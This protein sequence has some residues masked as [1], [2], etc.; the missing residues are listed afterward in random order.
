[1][2]PTAKE[3]SKTALIDLNT[4]SY[5][6]RAD[7]AGLLVSKAN[8][9]ADAAIIPQAKLKKGRAYI[10]GATSGSLVDVAA[11]HAAIAYYDMALLLMRPFDG[12]Y[13]TVANWKCNALTKLGQFETAAAWYA[14]IVRVDQEANGGVS[15]NAPTA[16]LAHRQ[17]ARFANKENEPLSYR[18]SDTDDFVA[19]P[20]TL[21]AQQCVL[22]LAKGKF[23]DGS[24]HFDV[25]DRN[26]FSAAYLK[27]QWKALVGEAEYSD[28]SITLESYLFEWDGKSTDD[29]GW[30]YFAVSSRDLHEGVECIVKRTGPLGTAIHRIAFGRP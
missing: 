2:S 24:M 11:L 23:A 6:H 3:A 1:M 20:F 17:L 29:I 18:D 4:L 25:G 9:L 21:Y 28:L 19:P 5:R 26:H 7:A 10:A 15:S 14:E 13:L 22:T 8:G 16:A 30:C 27:R 12:N